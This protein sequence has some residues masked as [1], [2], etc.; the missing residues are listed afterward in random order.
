MNNKINWQNYIM[1]MEKLMNLNLNH[2][3][4]LELAIQMEYIADIAVPLMAFPLE[5]RLSVAGVYKA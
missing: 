5:D 4:R 1:Q 2:S 3:S